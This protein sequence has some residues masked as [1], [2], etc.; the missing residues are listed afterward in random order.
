MISR[1]GLPAIVRWHHCSARATPSRAVDQ[2]CESSA[3]RMASRDFPSSVPIVRL[4]LKE[5][6]ATSLRIR[7]ISSLHCLHT[8]LPHGSMLAIGREHK[9]AFGFAQDGN[10]GIVSDEDHL[11]TPFD[12][13]QGTHDCVV[14]ERVVKVVFG[15]V[16]QQGALALSQQDWE[17]GRAPLAR[18]QL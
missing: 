4:A 3:R 1:F 6:F 16:N 10:V 7:S 17:D 8:D 2:S 14:D 12:S 11:A 5:G 18:G 15:L 9:H 13:A